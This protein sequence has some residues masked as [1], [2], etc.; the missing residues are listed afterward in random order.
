MSA[1]ERATERASAVMAR[2]AEFLADDL[3]DELASSSSWRSLASTLSAAAQKATVSQKEALKAA[4]LASERGRAATLELRKATLAADAANRAAEDTAARATL[5]SEASGALEAEAAQVRREAEKFA[6]HEHGLP[7][8]PTS[9]Y[10]ADRDL[11][12]I[13]VAV[14]CL[15]P[16]GKLQPPVEDELEAELDASGRVERLAQA[17]TDAHRQLE[18]AQ[19]GMRHGE[20]MLV[21]RAR[22]LIRAEDEHRSALKEEDQLRE[23]SVEWA[24]WKPRAAHNASTMH[25]AWATVLRPLED[26]LKA[27]LDHKLVECGV[28]GYVRSDGENSWRRFWT[29]AK[30]GASVAVGGSSDKHT[31]SIAS[32]MEM[33][34]SSLFVGSP[35]MFSRQECMAPL[36][37]CHCSLCAAR[38]GMSYRMGTNAS[39]GTGAM[40]IHNGVGTRVSG[41]VRIRAPRPDEAIELLRDELVQ[42][43][44][45]ARPR[46]ESKATREG[47]IALAQ[48]TAQKMISDAESRVL[49]AELEARMATAKLETERSGVLKTKEEA[50]AMVQAAQRAALNET[51]TSR[52]RLYDVTW[53][54]PAKS[55]TYS[56]LDSPRRS[57]ARKLPSRRHLSSPT[58]R[59]LMENPHSAL[60]LVRTAYEPAT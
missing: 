44:H 35:R 28:L 52:D 58:T 47:R 54:H 38:A 10:G 55:S 34:G 42:S 7:G 46:G 50:A 53:T 8:E 56:A 23:R 20:A 51:G 26:R 49:E 16:T 15:K 37:E 13:H 36:H 2:A 27:L 41:V 39:Q 6:H 24:K 17:L 57:D 40:Y 22:E 60:V 25:G 21:Q 19:R 31:T 3:S 30:G 18:E 4:A 45:A 9:A 11:W 32:S 43:L 29:Q 1:I 12:D 5:A 59:P 14:H 48:A 33:T